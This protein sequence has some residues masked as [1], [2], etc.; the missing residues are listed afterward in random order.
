MLKIIFVYLIEAFAI[1]LAA[2][3]IPKKVM[4]MSDILK[5]AATGAIVHL[6][7][8]LYSPLVGTGLRFGTGMSVGKNMVNN[9]VS[10]FGNIAQAGGK[11]K[12]NKKGGVAGSDDEDFVPSEPAPVEDPTTNLCSDICEG[13]AE[14]LNICDE[15]F[16]E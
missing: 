2:Y 12:K 10:L 16:R 8:D 13:D 14:C 6:L 11:K 1:A 5:I 15:A 3:Y 4:A 7:L 9:P